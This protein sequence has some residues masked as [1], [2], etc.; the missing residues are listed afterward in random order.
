VGCTPDHPAMHVFVEGVKRD[1]SLVC[2]VRKDRNPLISPR[3]P[4]TPGSRRLLFDH[5]LRLIM[6]S[7][8]GL[9][10]ARR[11]DAIFAGCEK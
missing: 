2:L 5:Q 7:Y 10:A 3:K 11:T 8:A 4:I 6:L 9:K 1:I